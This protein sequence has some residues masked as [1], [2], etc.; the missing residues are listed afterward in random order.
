MNN[1][2]DFQ[3]AMTDFVFHRTSSTPL[4]ADVSDYSPREFAARL[5]IY[6]NNTFHSLTEALKDLY[7]TIVLTIGEELFSAIARSYLDQHPPTSPAMVDF[8]PDFPVFLGN[9]EVSAS[10][11]YL[12]DLATLDLIRHRSYHAL[13]QIPVDGE[14]FAQLD[15]DTLISS[16]LTPNESA[17]L[18][19]S[20]YAIFDIWQLAYDEN[21]EPINAANQQF[22]LCI[23]S[24]QLQVELYQLDSSLYQFL[25]QLSNNATIQEAL[26]YAGENDN[27]FNPTN[28]IAFLIHSGFVAQIRG[29][30]Q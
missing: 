19:Q 6:Q 7:P 11:A 2:K 13:D 26:E 16:R 27:D 18:L 23:R 4:S 15:V 17:F 25:Y 30:Q 24:A 28:A 5:S 3:N 1:L 10:M 14:A 21:S 12:E 9:T 20:N 29:E 22:I 8:A